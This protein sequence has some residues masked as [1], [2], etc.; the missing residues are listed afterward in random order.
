MASHSILLADSSEDFLQELQRLLQQKYRLLSCSDGMLALE[1]LCREKCDMIVLDLMLPGLDGIT[2]LEQA[3]QAQLHPVILAVT[4]LLNDYV[5]HC[6]ERLHIRYLIRKPCDVRAVAA[7]IEDLM[8]TLPAPPPK[9]D[10]QQVIADLLLSLG[11]S[12]KHDGYSY[13][14]EAIARFARDPAQAFTKV[15]YPSVGKVFRHNGSHV[16]RSIRNAL[17]AAWK[18]R[19]TAL[20]C[21]YFP[22]SQTRPT[23]AA[24]ISRLAE[25]VRKLWE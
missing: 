17:D 16:E 24:V 4:P 12:P 3:T 11:L 21:Q 9:Q 2:L 5:L 14:A 15:L 20:W 13:L 25:E 19:D 10:E 23:S 8:L 18:H 1:L 22:A 7:R 6:A